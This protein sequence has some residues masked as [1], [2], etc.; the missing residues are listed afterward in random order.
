MVVKEISRLIFFILLKKT[1][2]ECVNKKVKCENWD[3]EF[4]SKNLSKQ[5][6]QLHAS[7]YNS[8]RRNESTYDSSR[9]NDSTCNSSRKKW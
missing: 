6:K 4:N 9:T 5:L 2:K 3:K 8:S 7:T 1:C